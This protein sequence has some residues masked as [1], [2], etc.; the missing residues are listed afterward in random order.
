MIRLKENQSQVWFKILQQDNT[1]ID[2]SDEVWKLPSADSKGEI[3]T[4][5]DSPCRQFE[6][7]TWKPLPNYAGATWLIS[8]PKPYYSYNQGMRI[9]IAQLF[10]PPLLEKPGMIWVEK[11]CLVREA[12]NLDLK[13]LGI[14]RAF[15]QKL[16]ND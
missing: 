14:H 4:F 3:V 7:N 13:R 1:P 15:E 9:F 11:T 2:G 12:T 16:S 8:D 10:A 6:D 5:S